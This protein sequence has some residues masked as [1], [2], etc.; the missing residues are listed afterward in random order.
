L[1][2][3][4]KM[5]YQSSSPGAVFY[6]KDG[7]AVSPGLPS[8]AQA[9]STAKTCNVRGDTLDAE[10]ILMG[11]DCII[12]G[13]FVLSLDPFGTLKLVKKTTGVE[14]WSN[15]DKIN[16]A[17]L[18]KDTKVP[19]A[20][21]LVQD[22]GNFVCY[23]D[24]SRANPYWASQTD[25]RSVGFDIKALSDIQLQI[26]TEGLGGVEVVFI[27]LALISDQIGRYGDLE[28]RRRRW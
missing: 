26:N 13:D 9:E 19:K 14:A 6:R 23:T 10:N 16:R 25:G 27:A 28:N 17:I 24:A 8:V 4:D 7:S 15:A 20:R 2:H 12:N 21:C 3:K 22:D 18:L 11:G 1:K 5:L